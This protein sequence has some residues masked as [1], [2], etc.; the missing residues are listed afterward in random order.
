V[1]PE[2]RVV[3]QRTCETCKVKRT[4]TRGHAD[5]TVHRHLVLLLCVTRY[6]VSY[7]TFN[8]Y[9]KW[10][11]TSYRFAFVAAAATYGIVVF[12]AHKARLNQGVKQQ[13]ILALLADENIQYLGTCFSCP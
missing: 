5:F 13:N 9:S 12:K 8:S 11:Q 7:V 2:Y 10:A 6:L 1:L 3:L 4:N